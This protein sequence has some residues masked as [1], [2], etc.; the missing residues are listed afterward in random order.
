M[1]A[2][3]R[4]VFTSFLLAVA[5]TML[6]GLVGF[7]PTSVL[8]A[9]L[10]NHKDLKAGQGLT[11]LGGCT[12]IS[13]TRLELYCN[14]DGVYHT[15]AGFATVPGQYRIDLNGS[16]NGSNAA[17]ADIYIDSSSGSG[18]TK[19]GTLTWN[20]ATASTQSVTFNVPS[21]SSHEVKI[22]ISSDNGSS[23]TYLYWY[24][25]QYVGPMPT[26]QPAPVPPSTGS[27]SSGVY[28]N[29]FKERGYTDAAISQKLNDAWASLFAST[30]DT[31][32]VYYTFDSDEAY[33]KDIGNGDI[34]SE[35][36]SYGMMIA[37]QMNKKAEFDKLWNFA[38]T[39][40][41]HKTGAREGYFCWQANTSGTC[42]DNN[43]ASDGEE[44]F[45]MA[46]YF[47]S[48]RWGNGTG[49]YN[50][51]AQADEL[52]R[53]MLHQE[54]DNGGVVDS[55][56][57]II[58]KTHHQVVFVPFASAASFTDPSYHLPA[59]Y[60]L[61]ALWGPSA[62]AAEWN[63]V[64]A[65][66]RA[67]WNQTLNST[68]GLGPDYAEFNG[69]PNNTGGHGDFRFDAW[70]IASNMGV[71]YAW[72][73]AEPS[74]KTNCDKLQAFLQSKG[75]STYANQ[76]TLSG[77]ALSSDHSTGMVAMTAACS[78][79][80]TNSRAWLFVDE[81]WNAP[82]PTGQWR[83]Y[84]G[85]LYFL[86]MLQVSGNYRIYA[87]GGAPSPT[88]TPVGPTPT[89]TNTPA[90]PAPT[91]TNTPVPPTATPTSAGGGGGNPYNLT[92]AEAWNSQSGVS[93]IAG[94]GGTVVKFNSTSS[95]IAF[96]NVNFGA[97]GAGSITFRAKDAGYGANIQVR[98]GS[99]T[100]SVL[101]TVYPSGGGVWATSSNT[102]YP[103]PTGTQTLYIT[104]T[105]ANVEINWFQ[106]AP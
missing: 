34:R 40:M 19:I 72:W 37:V 99:P 52:V 83:Y 54:D 16:S 63:T 77:T 69:A 18:G 73:A 43:S 24:E 29:L 33:I 93:N 56:Y 82:I 97:N 47:A 11:S 75:I 35:G 96:T 76:W 100:G 14:G 49:I 15:N 57:N 31:K 53:E 38:Y 71:D 12:G 89:R 64:A 59:F 36:M 44:Y 27:Y 79:A 84:D 85:M 1:K 48:G 61:F 60:K 103:K 102:C 74:E 7:A 90:G 92:Q 30:D 8:A 106:F 25:L 17:S 50:Y 5:I 94:D 22:T 46:L 6:T 9:T 91:A 28:R 78:L 66:S 10:M 65:T 3:Q 32:R 104:V 87:P 95:Y 45:A 20:S 23:D 70:R 62:D 105:S 51:R 101:C 55:T 98:V 4:F 26:Q 41:M 58:N 39:R 81:L 21:G 68:T 13:A 2:P 88:N 42:I 80:A 86:G 67:F